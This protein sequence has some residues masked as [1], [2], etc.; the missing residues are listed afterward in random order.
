MLRTNRVAGLIEVKNQ[1][2]IVKDLTPIETAIRSEEILRPEPSIK[3]G[4]KCR[5]LAGPLM[6]TEGIVIKTQQK[7]RLILQ[8]EMLGQATSVDIDAEMLELIIED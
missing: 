4:Q 2:R 6:G 3:E 8:V 7:Y 1:D 5:V